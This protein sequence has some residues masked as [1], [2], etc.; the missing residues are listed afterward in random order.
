MELIEGRALSSL[1]GGLSWPKIRSLLLSL[2]DAL[3]HAHARS[4]IHRD[5]KP[6]NVL[7]SQRPE[8]GWR[9][10][11]VDFGIAHQAP[12]ASSVATT[13][14]QEIGPMGTPAYMAPEQI[15]GDWRDHGPWTDLYALGCMAWELV[16]GR[17]PFDAS[18][19]LLLMNAHLSDPLPDFRPSV[20]VPEGFEGWVRRLLEKQWQRRFE[21][22]ADAAAALGALDDASMVEPVDDNTAQVRGDDLTEPMLMSRTLPLDELTL[23][24]PTGVEP[25][26]DG[27][28]VSP[29][30]RPTLPTTWRAEGAQVEQGQLLGAG[31]SLYGLKRIPVVDRSEIRDE[32]WG[33]LRSLDQEASRRGVLLDGPAGCGKSRLAEWLVERALE[34]GGAR[35][36][37]PRRPSG[38]GASHTGCSESRSADRRSRRVD[39]RSTTRRAR[40]CWCDGFSL[41]RLATRRVSAPISP[42]EVA[43]RM[44]SST[45]S[46]RRGVFFGYGD[47]EAAEQWAR[48]VEEAGDGMGLDAA[49]PDTLRARV[50]LS[51]CHVRHGRIDE[52]RE[53]L[54]VVFEGARERNN[55]S[56]LG[57]A[58][59]M[60][61]DLRIVDGERAEALELCRKS[62]ELHR[63]AD[64]PYD[65][66]VTQG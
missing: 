20:A 46:A 50:M 53:L 13:I 27:G 35:D 5:L 14:E 37:W 30:A 4:V 64:E 12:D 6:E 55:T 9:P 57:S 42:K 58:Y 65:V 2:L 24:H 19:A 15:N 34:V 43:R 10:K 26:E 41:R 33:A 39:G 54:D 45:G 8:G 48:R 32:L 44:P 63:E 7:V 49:H 56:A 51:A 59:R 40:R 16:C 3:A 23:E 17:P 60:Q 11:L 21:W 22:A 62:L 31:L 61:A 52:A 18:N 47:Y 38:G 1:L 36:S 29:V 28:E 66:A 25:S